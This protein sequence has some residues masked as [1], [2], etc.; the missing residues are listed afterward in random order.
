MKAKKNYKMSAGGKLKSA[1]KKYAN[2]GVNPPSAEDFIMGKGLEFLAS[3]LRSRN[4]GGFSPGVGDEVRGAYQQIKN[5]D[6]KL[7]RE[8]AQSAFQRAYERQ[9]SGNSYDPSYSATVPGYKTT[10]NKPAVSMVIK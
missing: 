9:G 1:M 5:S 7:A 8:I 6:P 10:Q 3:E 2:G 4:V